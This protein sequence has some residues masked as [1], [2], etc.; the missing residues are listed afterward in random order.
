MRRPGEA[1]VDEVKL[2]SK[3]SENDELGPIPLDFS[4]P[5]HQ[6]FGYNG[7]ERILYVGPRHCNSIH[8]HEKYANLTSSYSFTPSFNSQN[9][10]LEAAIE[11]KK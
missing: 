10:S 3:K 1:A 4:L 11:R 9:E 8:L 7:D 5:N 2:P 6:L